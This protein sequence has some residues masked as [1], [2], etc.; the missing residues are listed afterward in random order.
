MTSQITAILL[1]VISLALVSCT[2]YISDSP[3]T[4]KPADQQKQSV[5]INQSVDVREANA[6]DCVNG[7]VVYTIYLDMNI[8]STLDVDDVIVKKYPVCNGSR[9]KDGTDGKS[10]VDGKDGTDGA[11]GKNGTDGTNGKDGVGVA[12]KVVSA[13]LATCPA[14][15]STILMA[16][17]PTNSGVYDV[18]SANQQAMTICNGQNAQAPSYTPVEPIMACGE[19]VAYKEVLLRLSNGQVLGSFSNDIG[20]TMTRLAFLPDGTFMNTDSS[21]CVF[22]LATSSDG[23]TRSISWAGQVQKSWEIHY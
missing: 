11:D 21:A 1:S 17:D 23:K 13:D 9:G 7:G 2:D 5:Q 6:E 12:F 19:S 22:S 14:G 15:G 3:T 8:N 18:T 10:G 16:S 20:G 4:T